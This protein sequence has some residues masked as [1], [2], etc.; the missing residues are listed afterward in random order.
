MQTASQHVIHGT[1]AGS[2]N[3]PVKGNID[4]FLEEKVVHVGQ[5]LEVRGQLDGAAGGK[6]SLARGKRA[7]IR[8]D[9]IVLLRLTRA[10]SAGRARLPAEAGIVVGHRVRGGEILAP[11][12]SDGVY[13]P[14]QSACAGGL[15]PHVGIGIVV[16]HDLVRP[17]LVLE[18]LVRSSYVVQS[19]PAPFFSVVQILVSFVRDGIVV[20]TPD[21]G[22]SLVRRRE[23]GSFP[24][25][26]PV[27]R[28][29]VRQ[30]EEQAA[31]PDGAAVPEG[32]LPPLGIPRGRPVPVIAGR[33]HGPAEVVYLLLLVVVVTVAD[34]GPRVLPVR[35]GARP[36]LEQY[37]VQVVDGVAPVELLPPGHGRRGREE[38]PTGAVLRPPREHGQA[39]EQALRARAGRLGDGR[40]LPDRLRA[41]AHAPHPQTGHVR[42]DV[43][44]YVLLVSADPAGLD[45]GE[46]VVA[47]DAAGAL[48]ATVYEGGAPPHGRGWTH[49]GPLVATP[50]GLRRAV[51]VQ[52]VRD[53]VEVALPPLE[54]G[55]GT[56]RAAASATTAAT[57]AVP[58]AR[59]AQ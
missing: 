42:L 13:R 35:R 2:R 45:R 1:A 52:S 15:R 32:F 22:P 28:E 7:R 36:L 18:N 51:R 3:V 5:G 33:R 54:R 44:V 48:P 46:V 9:E 14:S 19:L 17:F 24:P 12:I 11:V 31:D 39:L 4:A 6:I 29:R 21:A 40:G 59:G 20:A 57:A 8:F 37:V 55:D 25:R 38:E 53:L 16:D 49:P 27:R 47:A 30:R 10:T 26:H 23:R 50:P 58:S 41:A 43:R 56:D 34:A